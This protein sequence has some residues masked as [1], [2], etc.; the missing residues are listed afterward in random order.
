MYNGQR[1][2]GTGEGEGLDDGELIARARRGDADAYEQLVRRY[3]RLVFRAAYLIVGEAAE[4][5]DV[6]QEAFVKAYYHLARFREGE[7]FR[8]WLLTI[9]ANE[10][11]NRRLAGARRAAL[12]LRA[13]TGRQG[14]AAPSPEAA[15]LARERRERLLLAL[16]GLREEERLAVACRY[17]LELN[18]A[19]MAA[20]LH[21]PRGTVKSRL[22]RALRR[23]R[24]LLGDRDGAAGEGTDG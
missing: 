7:P 11:R 14:E 2:A 12:A 4:A 6:A 21:C 8:P 15:A 9:A 18:E 22:S 13:G 10:A 1:R 3:E 19:E 16:A 5:E 24:A 17:F 20:L 23:L